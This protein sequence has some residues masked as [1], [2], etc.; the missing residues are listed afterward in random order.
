MS[1]VGYRDFTNDGFS[2]YEIHDFGSADE[3]RVYMDTKVGACSG[4]YDA[5]EGIHI[6]IN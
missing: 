2:Y 4:G 1:F 5:A 6:S 3:L